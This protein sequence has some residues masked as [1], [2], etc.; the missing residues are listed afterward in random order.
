MNTIL[1]TATFAALATLGLFAA[2]TARADHRH[3]LERI[4]TLS[5]RIQDESRQLYGEIR[6]VAFGDPNLRAAQNEVADIYRLASRIH[7]AAH[8]GGSRRQM[9]RDVHALKQLVHHSEEHLDHHRHL[10]RHIERIDRLTHDLED[11]VHK[12]SDRD[13]LSVSPGLGSP[14][15]SYGYRPATSGISFGGRG[16]SIQIG[17]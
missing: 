11:Y 13:F 12:L 5:Q 7:D 15:Y 3:D 17:R 16:F 8:Y 1:R 9:D 4:D 2:Q 14:G 6:S 10:R